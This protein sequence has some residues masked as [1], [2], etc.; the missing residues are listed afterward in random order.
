MI[1]N[2]RKDILSTA[3]YQIVVISYRSCHSP[4]PSPVLH[5][6]VLTRQVFMWRGRDLD[7][8]LL[9]ND[10]QTHCES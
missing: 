2:I 1:L 7:I 5:S 9:G 6:D 4:P 10:A 3:F 8:R